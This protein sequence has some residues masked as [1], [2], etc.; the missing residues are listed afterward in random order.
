MRDSSTHSEKPPPEA[1]ASPEDASLWIST[2]GLHAAQA[3]SVTRGEVDSLSASLLHR[4][5][6]KIGVDRAVGYTILGRGWAAGSG[7]VS[8]VVITAALTP[9]D[10]GYW[11]TFGSILG[12]QVFFELGLSVVVMQFASH[13]RAS[14]EWTRSGFMAGDAE[15][16]SRLAS[17]VRL[18]L[19]W[20]GAA[21][22]LMAVIVI[23]VGLRFFGS[24]DQGGGS[25]RWVFP[26]VLFGLMQAATLVMTP[27]FA[28]LEG[29]GKV[30]DVARFRM[31]QSVL[32]SLVVWSAL[33][34]G[35]KL[36][37]LPAM[38][39][40]PLIWGATWLAF[41]YRKWIADLLRSVSPSS[42]IR[43]LGEVWPFQWRLAVSWLSSYFIFQLFSPVLFAYQ[44]ATVAGQMGMSLSLSSSLAAFG[45]AW[46]STKA[47]A[48]GTLVARRD[49]GQLDRLFARSTF[50]SFC[51]LTAGVLSAWILFVYL[52]HAGFALGL[53]VL[54]P[55]PL[56]LL[57]MTTLVNQLVFAEAVYLRA[58]KREPFMWL[59]VA[60]GVTTGLST[61]ILGMTTGAVGV[62]AGYLACSTCVGLLGGTWVFVR[63]RRAWHTPAE[64]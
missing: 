1:P 60:S 25:V 64:S 14:L 29:C 18:S 58:H 36:F 4:A 39:A 38:S 20:Y 28:I 10:Q 9:V 52:R 63:R 42:R 43:W 33:L 44:G 56:G 40:V 8:A 59:S 41:K 6:R 17:L 37:A 47:P 57:L 23:P 35:W 22:V 15:A 61:W 21:A 11:Y 16:K 2:F 48:F 34:A 30:A 31:V 26:W 62:T 46:L 7:F 54:A 19:L 55:L 50:Q 3:S 27:V 49:F 5:A 45:M 13:E 53:R 32:N 51:V 12:L 24:S